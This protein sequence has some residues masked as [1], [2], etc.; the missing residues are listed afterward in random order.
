MKKIYKN[1]K[2]YSFISYIVQAKNHLKGVSQMSN[3]KLM[4]CIMY[5]KF[6]IIFF[7]LYSF[8][9]ISEKPFI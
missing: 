9:E 6:I 2:S 7:N 3:W 4:Q 5:M 8:G 1:T